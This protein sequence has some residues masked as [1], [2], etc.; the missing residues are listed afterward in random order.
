MGDTRV[1][2]VAS[3]ATVESERSLPIAVGRA[4][5][6]QRS[7]LS[8]LAELR[9]PTRTP[10]RSFRCCI[11][12][13]NVPLAERD[14]NSRAAQAMLPTQK[15]SAASSSTA[16]GGALCGSLPSTAVEAL[17]VLHRSGELTVKFG[18]E[19]LVDPREL[20]WRDDAA[21][22][23]PIGD[24]GAPMRTP[25]P[26]SSAP[27]QTRRTPSAAARR[28]LSRWEGSKFAKIGNTRC[29]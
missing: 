2:A 7:N 29:E 16:D 20:V 17:D 13:E 12:L 5:S 15:A 3:V 23:E 18:G 9:S 25:L 11:C 28:P 1:V 27:R 8:R 6:R 22:D 24:D 21:C 10:K 14:R 26:K 4:L 19:Q